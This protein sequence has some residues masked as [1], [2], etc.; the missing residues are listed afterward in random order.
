MYRK[1]EKINELSLEIDKLTLELKERASSKA[2]SS[3]LLKF[4]SLDV[5]NR[6]DQTNDTK[7]RR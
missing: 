3:T 6:N 1:D 4:Q 2:E 7:Q 5:D